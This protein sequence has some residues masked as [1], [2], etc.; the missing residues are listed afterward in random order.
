MIKLT[1]LTRKGLAALPLAL[2][3]LFL[4]WPA[5]AQTP[6]PAAQTPAR[7]SRP[8]RQGWLVRQ[9]DGPVS[10]TS[11]TLAAARPDSAWLTATMPAQV[12]DVLL[13]HGL[14]PDPHV[15]KNAA[16]SAWVGD[17]DW[18][19]ATTFKSPPGGGPVFLRLLGVDTLATATLNGKTVGRFDN[20]FRQWSL[21]VRENLAPPG[22]DN[23]LLVVFGSPNRFLKEAAARFQPPQGIDPAK[24]LRKSHGDLGSYLG[25]RPNSMKVGLFDDVLLD[26]PASAWLE[27]V[28]VRSTLTDDFSHADCQVAVEANGQPAA[29]QWTLTDPAGKEVGHGSEE[30][31]RTRIQ[32]AVDK[33]QLW[34]PATHGTPALYTLRVDLMAAGRL[35]DRRVVPFGIRRVRPILQDPQTGEK[36]FAFEVNGRRI[37][38]MGADWVPVEGATH[39][40]APGRARRLLDLA[41]Q[42]R[43]NVIRVWAEG[44]YPPQE[45]YNECDRR[46]IFVWQ[47]FMFGYGMHPMGPPQLDS[48]RRAEVEE[49]IRRLRNHPSLLLWVGGNENHM[50]WNFATGNTAAPGEEF[51]NRILPEV[52]ARLDPDRL[53]HPSSPYGG[54]VPNWPL[55]GDWHDYTTL[56]FSPQA[57]VPTYASEVGRVSSPSV[58]SL[59]RY[60]SPQ[61]I[62]P[63]NFDARTTEP[64]RAA[65][66]PMWQYR[67]VDGAWDKI[68]PVQNYPDPVS[69]E[70]LVRVLGT[71]HGEYL[72]E[73]VERERRGTPDGAPDGNRRCWGNMVWRLNDSWPIAYWSVIDYYL[74]PKIPFYFLRRAYAPVLLSFERTP[75]RIA[76]WVTNDSP[77]PV[78]GRLSVRRVDFSGKIMGTLTRDVELAPGDSRRCI[79]LTELGPVKLRNE[80]LQADLGAEQATMLLIAER[81]LHLPRAS[82]KVRPGGGANGSVVEISCDVFARQ[83]KLE[84]PGKSGAVFEDNFFDLAPGQTRTIRLIDPAGGDQ[85]NVSALNARPV[86][87]GLR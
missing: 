62:W 64:G 85:L 20:M 4:A 57:S 61:E 12:H 8:L 47:D 41:L 66:P 13:A 53:Y 22:Q 49:A 34:W 72:R 79:D 5:G 58:A 40:W 17:K 60:M 86:T 39:V 2:L 16:R 19:C 29:L 75:D 78:K 82:L 26:V 27:D 71:A 37:F 28:W 56:T 55:E 42:G 73:R 46:G 76:L 48:N 45:F 51:F 44:L 63:K 30:S 23:Q 38:L 77:A 33:P 87:V 81:D 24:Y 25:A 74:E 84:I 52:C 1:P 59:R 83:V 70:D 43:M 18:A 11:L 35:L 6:G 36:R 31:G 65:W 9:L 54:P 80:F 50:G 68:G 7:Q 67:S 14:I 10:I 69:A 15:G 21:Q 3:A 32:F